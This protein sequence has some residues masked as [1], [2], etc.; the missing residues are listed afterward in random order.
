MTARN[1]R[2]GRGV[3]AGPLERVL[4]LWSAQGGR[5][6]ADEFLYLGPGRIEG[7]V[8]HV[9]KHRR[10]RRCLNLD[11]A[12]HAYVFVPSPD[13]EQPAV[14]RYQPL[15]SLKSAIMRLGQHEAT[16]VPLGESEAAAPA[17]AESDR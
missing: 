13:T 9:Y 14:P 15:D 4:G 6:V 5:L 10:S 16:V 11:E 3:G 7:R 2:D 17:P 1:R 12:G 8:V